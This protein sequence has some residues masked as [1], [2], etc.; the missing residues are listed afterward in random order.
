MVSFEC[1]G[2]YIPESFN[3]LDMGRKRLCYFYLQWVWTE[4][5]LIPLSWGDFL[6]LHI[7]FSPTVHVTV[8][9]APWNPHR[10]HP[11]LEWQKSYS[12]V[13]ITRDKSFLSRL[14]SEVLFPHSCID[15]FLRGSYLSQTSLGYHLFCCHLLSHR[16]VFPLSEALSIR[17]W[18]QVLCHP[19]SPSQLSCF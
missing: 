14:L 1:W 8:I 9:L 15:D 3:P 16:W 10:P 4:K 12:S 7:S 18:R 5:Y 11:V 2:N 6:R 17:V 13:F 19:K